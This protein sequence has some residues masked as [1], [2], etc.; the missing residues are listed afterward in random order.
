MFPANGVWVVAGNDATGGEVGT[1]ITDPALLTVDG[2]KHGPAI[3]GQCCERNEKETCRRHLGPEKECIFGR[4]GRGTFRRV[5]WAEAAYGCARLGLQLCSQSCTLKG[6]GYDNINV[7]TRRECA[8]AVAADAAAA[9][10]PAQPTAAVSTFDGVSSVATAAHAAA[11]HAAAANA[12]AADPAAAHAAA[13]RAAAA[14]AAAAN[15]GRPPGRRRRP[16]A[17]VPPHI[18]RIAAAAAAA[19]APPAPPPAPPPP[20]L[21]PVPPASPPLPPSCFRLRAGRR[22]QRRNGRR[23]R[24]VCD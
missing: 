16:A 5:T 11:A 20:S 8:P 6:C 10:A 15:A 9:V 22:W 23:C 7:W 2:T 17:V 14:Q 24:H 1:C 21:P 3:A 13:A 18:Q 19:S 4:W 12:A